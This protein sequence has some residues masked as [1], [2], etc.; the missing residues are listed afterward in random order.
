MSKKRAVRA[1]RPPGLLVKVIKCNLTGGML[2]VVGY[3]VIWVN[4]LG[5]VWNLA[6]IVGET[7]LARNN[8]TW[9]G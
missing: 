7:I 1:R 9:P 4:K 6:P 2:V 5:A 3:V 8:I